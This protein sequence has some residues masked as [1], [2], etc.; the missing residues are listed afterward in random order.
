[1]I[2]E[3]RNILITGGRA[4][5]AL[6]LARLFKSAGH[7]VYVAESAEYHLCRGSSAVEASFRVPSP[8][9]QPQ[10]Y[11]RRL[12]ALTEELDIHCLIPTCEEIFYIAAGLERLK[13]CRVLAADRSIL[14]GLHHKGEFIARVRSLGFAVPDTE[15]ISSAAEWQRAAEQA[16]ANGEQRVYKPAYSRFASKVILPAKAS[17]ASRSVSQGGIKPPAGISADAPWVSQQYIEGT[18][19]CTYSIV[20]EGSVVAHAAYDS[21]Y[22]TGRSGASVYFESLEH[23]A[24]LD[25]VQRYAG[26]TGFSGQ[27]GFDF[28]ESENGTLYPIECNPRATSGIHLFTPE[29]GLTEALLNPGPLVKSGAVILPR[30]ARKAMLTLPMLGCVLKLRPG[31]WGNW[32][33]ALLG[34]ADVISR[35]GDHRPFLEQFR[36]VY[37]ACKTAVR[38]RIS[39][40]EAL[41]EDIEW[42]GEA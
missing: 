36:V 2:T 17:A 7:R 31:E 20:H 34:A 37:A 13:G 27:I 1:M 35:K 24:S 30:S 33:R 38:C 6:E 18:A 39:I 42:N 32:R 22:R 4:P 25:W 28:I 26:A 12:A 14:G 29:D 5:V 16:A 40:T 8:R 11:V 10:A 23:P 19:I 41:T 9:H 15:L 3:A 21:R